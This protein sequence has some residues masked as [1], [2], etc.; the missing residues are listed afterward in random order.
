[1]T[2]YSFKANEWN[3][4]DF[5]YV[6]SLSCNE[7]AKFEQE[8][9]CVKSN[10]G[11]GMFGYEYISILEKKLRK[12][13]CTVSTRCTFETFGAPLLVFTN[14][15]T[16]D[17]DGN[18]RYGEHYEVVA[19]E[20]GCNVWHIIPAPEGSEKKVIP[21]LIGQL[22]FT[23]ENNEMTDITVKFEG[24]TMKINMNGKTLDLEIPNFPDEFRA[25]ITA[26]EGINRF[27]DFVI[28]D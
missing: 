9:D 13:G 10:A 19:Y 8:A 3:V 11:G 7:F 16:V 12:S 27:Y 5:D 22:Q 21:T 17:K 18:Y 6:Y 26:C 23:I 25:G 24:K 1:M 20:K 28:E 4:N 2:K 14:D 15:V